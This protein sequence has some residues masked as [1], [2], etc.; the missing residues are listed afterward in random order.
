[1]SQLTPM[2]QLAKPEEGNTG[3]AGLVNANFDTLDAAVVLVSAPPQ[4][5]DLQVGQV[6]AYLDETLVK[7]TTWSATPAAVTPVSMPT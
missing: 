5:Q 2:L 3:W 7:S 1:M 4:A 6:V